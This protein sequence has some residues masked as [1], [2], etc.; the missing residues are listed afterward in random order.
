[1]TR[2]LV[3]AA[4]LVLGGC[5]FWY[6][7]VPVANAVGEE[8]T[9]I[10]GDTVN[11]YR[12]DRFEVYGPNTE[13]VYDGYEQLSRSY[14]AFERHF[15]RPAPR[16][17]VLMLPDS[18]IPVDSTLSRSFR[19]RGFTLIHYSRP[20]SVRSRPRYRGINYGGV[21]WP[22]AP[23]AVRAMLARFADTQLGGTA[24]PDSVL[25]NRFP[26][27]YRAA[28]VRVF[29]DASTYGRDIQHVREK[30][31]VLIPLRDMLPLVR[32]PRADSLIDPSRDDEDFDEYTETLAAQAG[33]FAR[34]LLD[35]EGPQV[36]ERLGRGYVAGRSFQ[37]MMAEFQSVPSS[38]DELERRWIAWVTTRE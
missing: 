26:L 28:V 13:A 8:E 5:R 12:G 3:L 27:W 23:T 37:Q 31:D 30:R 18:M 15:G 11:V 2:A 22:I 14:R 16:L 20:P 38:M 4:A 25:L 9:V 24:L 34:Y 29:G 33:T 32:T 7:P 17:A 19:A 36:L 21:L 6:K 1:V 35:R 10:G